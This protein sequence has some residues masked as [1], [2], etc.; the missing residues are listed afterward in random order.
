[1]KKIFALLI[2]TLVISP[3]FAQQGK[4]TEYKAGDDISKYLPD[5]LYYIFPSFTP[6]TVIMKGGGSS[7]SVINICTLDQTLRFIDNNGDTLRVIDD[8][9]IE[10]IISNHR[11]FKRW[12]NKYIEV[13]NASSKITLGIERHLNIKQEEKEG[14]YGFQDA[15]ASSTKL[16][17][18]QTTRFVY[19]EKK[20]TR[21][22]SFVTNI[23]FVENG[24]KFRTASKKN[25]IKYFPDQK[26]FILDYL[27][28]NDF[29][30]FSFDQVK[31]LFDLCSER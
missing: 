7:F 8:N 24:K 23:Y 11:L 18:T 4:I 21:P 5:S 30:F 29:D 27:D 15:A 12:G 22:Y 17:A 19:F 9:A 13:L 10:S 14:A 31:E 3:L 26:D 20:G 6:G 25:F 28:K 2:C 16:S 1:M